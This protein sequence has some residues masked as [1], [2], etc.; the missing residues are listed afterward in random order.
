MCGK[1]KYMNLNMKK[2]GNKRE[3]NRLTTADE[4]VMTSRHLN[5]EDD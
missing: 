3:K 1:L 2:Q 4:L 5:T